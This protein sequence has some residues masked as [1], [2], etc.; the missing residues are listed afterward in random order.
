MLQFLRLRSAKLRRLLRVIKGFVLVYCTIAVVIYFGQL[1]LIFH[2][3]S[4]L[5][6]TPAYFRLRHEEVWLPV[7][8]NSGQLER[9][10]GWWMP[11][12]GATLGTLI[13]LHGNGI[14]I[15]ANVDQS[16]RFHKLGFAVLLID[17]RGFGR[18]EGGFPSEASVYQDAETAWNYLIQ[19]RYVPK[20]EIFIY[21]HSLG[22]A[23]AIDLAIRHPQAAALIVQSSFTSMTAMANRQ[24]YSWL[25][26]A[27]LLINQRFDSL[28]KVKA[29]Q[30]PVLFI[31]GTADAMIPDVMSQTLYAAAPPPKQLLLVPGGQHNNAL[32]KLEHLA[33]MQQF[34]EDVRTGQL[35][36]SQ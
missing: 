33:I 22:G 20:D 23:V 34:A 12:D 13:Y 14:N 15:G 24:W 32:I 16:N 19:E 25:F 9:I 27:N 18:S 26:P 5:E 3:T 10:H 36:D 30:L 4:T 11:A 21:G 29:L 7:K 2:P 6:K 28:E 17:Y 8:T 1:R 31:H 35:P